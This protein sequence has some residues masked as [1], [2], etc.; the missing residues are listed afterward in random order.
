M[1]ISVSTRSVELIQGG[2]GHVLVVGPFPVQEPSNLDLL[3]RDQGVGLAPAALG[4]IS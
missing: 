2:S 1:R 4:E 3:Q